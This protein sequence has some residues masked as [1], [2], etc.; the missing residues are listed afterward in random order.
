M[1]KALIGLQ[2]LTGMLCLPTGGELIPSGGWRRTAPGLLISGVDPQARGF[3][4]VLSTTLALLQQL[5]LNNAVHFLDE[6][7]Y[8]ES[9]AVRYLLAQYLVS[10]DPI[11]V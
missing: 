3:G 7:V 5:E 9:I 10:F 1:G 11:L 4:L 2:M 8:V 6:L